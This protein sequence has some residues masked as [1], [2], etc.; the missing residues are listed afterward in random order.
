[1]RIRD[2]HIKIGTLSPGRNNTISDVEGVKVGHCTISQGD[3]QTGVTAVIPHSGNL[4][5][6]KV[7]GAIH[8]I[9]G[10][11]KTT[12]SIQLEELGTIETPIILTNTFAV[13]VGIQGV[14]DY[15]LN[16][17]LDIGRTTGT[18]NSIVCECN[19]MLI[20]DI[21]KDSL[22]KNHVL[23]A[24]ESATKDFN[25]GSLGAGTG[26]V[27]FGLKGGIG[28]SSRTITIHNEIYTLGVLVLSNFGRLEHL[29]IGGKVVGPLIKELLKEKQLGGE[30]EQGSIIILVA[31]DAPLS[32][33]QVKRV[34]KRTTVGLSRTGSHI[35]NGSGDI[36]IGFTTANKVKHEDS[37]TVIYTNQIIQDYLLDP[38]FQAAA[39]ATEE[40]I[41]DSMLAANTTTARNGQKIYSLREFMNTLM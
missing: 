8:T 7:V 25:Q 1:M 23:E 40:A 39:E 13:G 6:E 27:S 12:G 41:L 37:N 5:K 29:T 3:I 33:R 15:T 26:M 4:F 2:Y 34:L 17:N 22:S 9:N 18:V 14:I 31:T 19:D 38:I 36:A 10:F 21:R 20:N 28:S 30:R 11:G 32:E 35:G 16:H 24:I